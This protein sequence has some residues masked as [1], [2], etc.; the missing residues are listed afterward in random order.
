MADHIQV[1][2][3]MCRDFLGW[4][5][6]TEGCMSIEKKMPSK[7]LEEVRC[8]VPLQLERRR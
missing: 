7:D 3:M 1:G 2:V 8:P 4:Y 6:T 5:L